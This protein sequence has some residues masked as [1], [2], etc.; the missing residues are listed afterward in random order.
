[1]ASSC[2][3]RERVGGMRYH[4]PSQEQIVMILSS[5]ELTL[6]DFVGSAGIFEIVRSLSGRADFNVIP[7]SRPL[8]R[9][10]LAEALGASLGFAR[11]WWAHGWRVAIPHRW[12]TYRGVP[13]KRPSTQLRSAGGAADILRVARFERMVGCRP[14]TAPHNPRCAILLLSRLISLGMADGVGL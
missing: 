13:P 11:P 5:W 7:C 2:V 14:I 8:S 6:D 12:A 1:M 10:C 4:P 3:Q 9:P